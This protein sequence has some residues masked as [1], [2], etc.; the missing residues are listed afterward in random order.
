MLNRL[1]LTHQQTQSL[2]RALRNYIHELYKCANEAVDDGDL[3]ASDKYI[4]E[5]NILDI[6][7]DSLEACY[8]TAD[9]ENDPLRNQKLRIHYTPNKVTKEDIKKLDNTDSS[10]QI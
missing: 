2:I 3:R 8:G 9:C 4:G 1:W 5:A 6:V 10:E 7:L